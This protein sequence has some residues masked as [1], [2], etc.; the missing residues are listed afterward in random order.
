MAGI[1]SE[2]LLK[3]PDRIIASYKVKP[4]SL[5]QY[6]ENVKSP[7]KESLKNIDDGMRYSINYMG[8][9]V[10]MQG[11]DI[12]L[13]SNYFIEGSGKCNEETSNNE[14]KGKKRFVYVRNIPTGTIPPLNISFYNATGC[15]LTGLTEGRGLVPGLVEDVYDFN[16]VEITRAVSKNGN[17][18]SDVCKKM[19]LPVGSKIYDKDEENKSWVWETKCTSGHHTMTETTDKSLNNAVKDK[20]KKIRKARLPGPLQL[21]ENFRSRGGYR[22]R[23]SS[24]SGSSLSQYITMSIIFVVLMFMTNNN[25]LKMY[26][27]SFFKIMIIVVV[28]G[29]SIGIEKMISSYGFS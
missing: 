22:Y 25:I 27:N 26:D 16:P 13:G 18:G 9:G 5:I 12:A 24:S 3:N 7:Y 21:R 11:N 6:P 15:N 2:Y 17:I 28:V 14:C 20:N 1:S 10:D 19:T 8:S 23:G 4:N 29:I